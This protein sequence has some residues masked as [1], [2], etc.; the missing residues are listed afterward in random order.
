VAKSQDE[1]GLLDCGQDA[2]SPL[3]KMSQP[4]SFGLAAIQCI[5][6]I[7]NAQSLVKRRLSTTGD[8]DRSGQLHRL[9]DQV[10]DLPVKQ[11][12]GSVRI[13]ILQDPATDENEPAEVHTAQI[14]FNPHSN[15]QNRA[16]GLGPCH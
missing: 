2:N 1:S 13:S 9:Y 14:M 15:I 10:Q 4:V 7:S 6:K 12:S 8:R 5:L 16:W 11:C 3:L